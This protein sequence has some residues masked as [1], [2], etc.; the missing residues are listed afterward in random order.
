MDCEDSGVHPW[1]RETASNL[2]ERDGLLRFAMSEFGE[3]ASCEGRVTQEFDETT[4]GQI[5]FELE[6][7]VA[8]EFETMPPAVRLAALWH[9]SGFAQELRILDAA[10]EY[11]R[12]LGL[13]VEWEDPERSS[14]EGIEAE[15]YWDPDPGMNGSVTLMRRGGVL[16]G[17]TVSLAP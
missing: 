6:S 8:L 10:R 5:V 17:V 1:V 2:L 13:A 15:A 14:R 4:F 11:A 9:P 16:V 3:V 12:G 7:G